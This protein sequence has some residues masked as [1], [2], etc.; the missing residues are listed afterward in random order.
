[1]F[2]QRKAA[3]QQ[4]DFSGHFERTAFAI[5]DHA[6]ANTYNGTVVQQFAPGT[7]PRPTRRP[8]PQR[9]PPRDPVELLGREAELQRTDAALRS[10]SAIAFHGSP[11]AGKTALLKHVAR[12]GGDGWPDGVLY[13]NVGAQPLEDVLQWLFTVFWDTGA[14]VYAPGALGVGEYLAA[15]RA[16]VVLDDVDLKTA[17]VERLL[18]G[19]PACAFAIGAAQPRLPERSHALGGLGPAAA[20]GVFA[21]VLGRDPEGAEQ[22]AVDAFV[23]AVGGLPGYVVTGAELVRDG[24]CGAGDLVEQ[25]GRVLARRRVLA[26]SAPQQELLGLLAELAPAPVPAERL[27]TDAQQ[28]FEAL[29]EAGL[30]ERHSPRYTLAGS[31]DAELVRDLPHMGAAELLRRL[32]TDAE[33]IGADDAPAAVAA[34]EWGRRAGEDEEVLRA[35]RALAPAMVR[36]GRT[37]AWAAVAT[38]GLEAARRTGRRAD[39][40]LFLHEQGSRLGCLGDDSA[41]EPLIRARD[42]R[43]ELGDE[44]ALAVTEHNLRELFGEPG[45]PVAEGDDPGGPGDGGWRPPLGLFAAFA[46]LALIVVIALVARGGDDLV[47][48]TLTT[49]TVP[50]AQDQA[51]PQIAL[52]RPRDGDSFPAGARVVAAYRCGDREGPTPVCRGTVRSGAAIDTTEGEHEFRVEA[53]DRT[54][55][56]TSIGVTYR[57]EKGA[58]PAPEIVITSPADGR[59]YEA[60]SRIRARYRCTNP[61]AC[62]G[63]VKVGEPVNGRPGTHDFTVRATGADGTPVKETVIYTVEEENVDAPPPVTAPADPLEVDAKAVRRTSGDGLLSTPIVDVVVEYTCSGGTPPRDCTATLDDKPVDS[64]TRIGCGDHNVV[65]RAAD[66]AGQVETGTFVINGPNCRRSA[67]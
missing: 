15:M 33:S 53:R 43:R 66:V 9:R 19:A 7:A 41:Y 42:I 12:D 4:V 27:G 32:A 47:N 25:A 37:G 64:G 10:A 49:E 30:V 40:A 52:T 36:S 63:G 21:R 51:P 38:L 5:G 54:G 14:V 58:A 56:L 62:V 28:R 3:P 24:V 18:D 1:M 50:G 22:P 55:N 57:A 45:G 59:T 29:R 48:Q 44:E 60:G 20:R 11:G 65:V 8:P 39:E 2:W 6:V 67:G 35:A 31:L 23:A 46:A 34:L 16:L 17:D 61:S 26:L 13:R